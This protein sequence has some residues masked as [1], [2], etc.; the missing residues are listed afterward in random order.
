MIFITEK[1]YIG[2]T[3]YYKD[4]SRVLEKQWLNLMPSKFGYRM[5]FYFLRRLGNST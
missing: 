3:F 1:F 2:N 4:P 5:K